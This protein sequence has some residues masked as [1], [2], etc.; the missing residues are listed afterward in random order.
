MY[1]SIAVA[2][3]YYPEHLGKSF[4][5]VYE[6]V[7]VQRLE[8]KKSGNKVMA[9][10]YKLSLNSVYGKSNSEYSFCYDPLY[11]VKITLTGE[12]SLCMLSEM[13]FLGIPDLKIL[14][15]NTDGITVIIPKEYKRK[16]WEI[17]KEWENITKLTLEYLAY[18]KMIMRDVSNYLAIDVKGKIKRK[19]LFKLH[20][21]MIEDG[22][23]HKAFNQGIVPIALS[24]YYLNGIKV[25]DTILNNRNIFN[26][27]KTFNAVRNW[28]CET[29]ILEGDNENDLK[30][31]QKN[32]RYYISNNGRIFR[33]RSKPI[34]PKYNKNINL[35]SDDELKYINEVKD[36]I[37][38]SIIDCES[39]SIIENREQAKAIIYCN[40]KLYKILNK[41]NQSLNYI[42][43]VSGVELI[44]SDEF[45]V[46]I[47]MDWRLISI[48]SENLITI[49]NK[50]IEFEDFNQYDINYQYY[51][52]ECYKVIDTISHEKE[53]REIE[54]KN[55]KEEEKRQKEEQNYIK[56]CVEKPPT[57][58][59]F[60]EYSREW[61]INKYGYPEVFKPTPIRKN[62][63]EE[64]IEEISLT[65]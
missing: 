35:L 2:N 45:K 50:L 4:C 27:T 28:K 36:M 48:E 31:E 10:G 12:L 46:Q 54:Q 7:L 5:D 37:N 52:D 15:I 17:C 6:K 56:Y 23:Y 61:L 21:E 47:E 19:G 44:K 3:K 8:A 64:V 51:I 20:S 13:L 32:N 38:E 11:T 30:E 62:K 59:Q 25:E 9:D 34:K 58:R 65:N 40:D 29:F 49:F 57:A 22:E 63:K 14:Q 24:E 43:N 55:K 60:Q 26:F 39:S 16:Y 1:P 18:D 41:N 42:F 33:K 53:L